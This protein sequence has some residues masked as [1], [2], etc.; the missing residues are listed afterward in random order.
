MKKAK[1]LFSLDENAETALAFYLMTKELDQNN[2]KILSFSRL[3]WPLLSIQGVIQTHIILDGITIFAKKGQF[4]NP[5]RQPLIGHILRNVDE[6]TEIEL[7]ERITDVLKYKD[8]E[9][10]VIG[11]G[12]E[13]EFRTLEVKGL[14]NPEYLQSIL[15]LIPH[16]EYLP[17][18]KYVPLDTT[19]NTEIALN[20]S[21]KY[22]SYIETM[23]GNAT[24][25]ESQIKLIGDDITKWM[26]NLTVELKDL[27]M[28][29]SSQMTKTKDIIDDDQLKKQIEMEHDK[30]D[31]WNGNEKRK[32]I[33][34]ISV[35]FKTAERQLQ[36]I[37]RKNRFF[38]DDE[39][40]KSKVFKDLVPQ[41]E[42]QFTFIKDEANRFITSVD[43]L[44]QKFNELKDQ[45]NIVDSEASEK[46]ENVTKELRKK[47]D[48]RNTQLSEIQKEKEEKLSEI[49]NFKTQI[50]DLFNNINEIIKKKIDDC[51]QEADDLTSWSIKD[52]EDELFSKPIQ[53]IYMPFY[54]AFVENEELMEEKMHIVFPG[55]IGDN[56]ASQ[57][58][59]LSDSF[60]EFKEIVSEKIDDDVKIR[61]N[62]E[63]SSDSKNL[64]KDPNFK[65]EV[66][67]GISILKK[68]TLFNDEME[69]QILKLLP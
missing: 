25:W 65:A 7:L 2:E 10:E 39:T 33:E 20:V 37:I 34:N 4:T 15:K 66:N 43:S 69:A 55:Y 53:W 30:I 52:T 54:V 29:Y 50:E 17:I 41:F 56:T 16:L 68:K 51:Q 64:L 49:N 26:T 57:Y 48:E 38:S 28:R 1:G 9:A 46:L 8:A 12:E 44:Y 24:R 22:R 27:D 35:L 59:N 11:M 42:N 6:R 60:I 61:S 62:F 5:P 14:L 58:E 13:S 32:I 31:Q 23:N 3:L 19:L 40:L 45:A 18:T 47:L 63:F 36:E 67:Q 21:E